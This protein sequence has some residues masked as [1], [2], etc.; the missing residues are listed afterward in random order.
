VAEPK[1][2]RGPGRP[3]STRAR[4]AILAA[5]LDLVAEQGGRGLTMEAIARRAGTSKETV[6]RWWGSKA[7]IVLEALAERGDEAIAIPDTG[8]LAGDLHV[9]LHATV[10]AGDDATLRVLRALAAEA[11]RDERFRELVR[12]RFLVRRRAALAGVLEHAE[13]RGELDPVDRT[14]II[15]FVFGSLWYRGIFGVGEV[16]AAWADD[17]TRLV[18]RLARRAEGAAA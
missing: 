3:R 16:D 1:E 18:A 9:F 6:Y 8:T 14:T 10:E 2:Q 5:A 17:V 13:L 11:A 4:A 7:E 12:E 15:D